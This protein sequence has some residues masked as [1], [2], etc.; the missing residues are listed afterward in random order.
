MS[1]PKTR[2]GLSLWG[3]AILLIAVLFSARPAQAH[4]ITVRDSSAEKSIVEQGGQLLADYGSS[5]LYEVD[6]VDPSVLQDDKA[7]IRDDYNHVFLNAARLDTMSAAT[8]ARRKPVGA[9]AGKRLHL[10]QFV[11]P[12]LPAWHEALKQTG[13]RIVSYIP[14]NTYLVYGDGPSLAQLQ[15]MGATMKSVQWDGEYQKDYKIHP[16][17]RPFD[18]KGNPRQLGTDEFA[19]Q[20]VED[21]DAN[22]ATLSLIDQLKLEPIHRQYNFLKCVNV[23]VRLHP[24]DLGRVAA[25]PDVISIQPYMEPR[26]EDERQD[27]IVAG[28]LTGNSPTGPGYLAWLASIGF[29]QSQFTASG[30]IVDITDA[31]IDDGT[32]NPGHFALYTL[33]DTNNASRVAYI[34]LEG[35]PNDGSTLQ[36]CDGHGNINAHIVCAYDPGPTNFPHTDS[37]G[38]FYDIGVCPFVEVGSSVIFDPDN[39]T[40]PSFA[41]LESQAYQDGARI[42]NNSWGDQDT[43][44]PYNS[45]SQAFDALVRDAQPSGSAFAANGN[46]EMVIVFSAG[47]GN[48]VPKSITAPGTGK[49]VFTVGGAENVRSMNQSNGGTDPDGNDGCGTPDSD[50]KSANNIADF[51]SQGPCSDGRHKPDIVAPCSHITGGAPQS[52]PPPSPDGTGL[53]LACFDSNGDGIC[54][55]ANGLFFPINQQFFT[56]SSGTSHSAPAVSGACA[57]LR[58]YFLNQSLTP[59]SPAMTKAYL[60]NSARY[61]TGSGANDDLWSDSQG[62]GELD[63]GTAFDGVARILRDQLITDIFTGSGQERSFSGVISDTSKPFRVTV[64]WS[65]APG[66]TASAAL[67]NDLDLTVTVGGTTY[68]GNVFSGA[69][70]V[71]GGSA[72]HLNN[73]ES[74]FLPAGTTGSF[75]VKITAANIVA[76]GVDGS[77]ELQQD[78]ALVIY[79]GMAVPVPDVIA[80]SATVVSESCLPTN[81]AIDPS[82]TVTVDF[83]L[84]N[85]GTADTT[86]VV[87]TLLPTGGVD[88]PSGPQAYGLLNTNGTPVAQPFSFIAAGP[89]GGSIT[90]TFQIQDG[91]TN[92]GTVTFI[93]PLG[94]TQSAFTEDFDSVT[95]PALP[96]GWATS[97]SGA[98]S[99]WVTSTNSADTPPN[100]AFSTDASDVGVNELDTPPI[101]VSSAHAQLTFRQNY[102]LEDDST[103]PSVGFDGGVL[104]IKIGSGAY[105]DIL[106]AG[107]SFVSGGYNSTISSRYGNPLAGRH[108][109]S[110]DSAGFVTTVVKLPAAAA[111]QM[112][113]LRWRCGTDTG[114]GETVVGWYIDTVSILEP[115]CCGEPAA[116]F[117]AVA[118]VYQGLIQSNSPSQETSG[119]ISVTTVKTNTYSATITLNGITYS[120]K[121]L[122]DNN[123]FST[124]TIPRK[125]TNSLT[126]LLELDLTNGT[127]Q[128]TGALTDGTFTSDVTANRATF[129]ART[130]PATQFAGYYTVLLP[131]NPG[132]TGPNFPQGNGFGSVK[133]DAGGTVRL[134]ATLGDGTKISQTAAVSKDGEWPL[135]VP[136]YSKKGSISGWVT[137]TN[138]VG[139]SDLGGTLSW[140]K[141]P[142]PGKFY[143]NGFASQIMFLGSA[144]TNTM[145]ALV[146]SNAPCNILVTAG[147]GN[148]GAFASNTITL[149]TN[150]KTAICVT[151]KLKLTITPK[152]GFFSG[153]FTNPATGKTLPFTGALLQ[154]QNVGAGL[155]SGT[156]QTGF[157]TVEPAP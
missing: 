66:S 31:G 16:L 58:Q 68:K 48:G 140:F 51:A 97:A 14:N 116:N 29:T 42:S 44:A 107:G 3:V 115:V 118:G 32:T 146:V 33:G 149:N 71:V 87:A 56:E 61:M 108:A 10:I 102:N 117:A 9:F 88:A 55:D 155:F 139:V 63:L 143:T 37:T 15:S 120:V 127:D 70:S 134:S 105:Q 18:E 24:Q 22:P 20:L 72:D 96:A 131:P 17:A 106:T 141:P 41:D 113:Q 157:V 109:W 114:N 125:G 126:M 84:K 73:V 148:L 122:F 138:I 130:N 36:S 154:K 103:T 104:E 110:G 90:N 91:G 136:L 34:R 54:G 43:G 67:N 65:D 28:N 121:G 85:V 128:I 23:F 39:F 6:K 99:P 45:D 12:V 47:N 74:V 27:Q 53:A 142:V 82:E 147:D 75:T 35:T 52:F 135:F 98:Q 50:A 129:N 145:P 79:N 83:T 119:L 86:N 81:G 21:P 93:L 8:K 156:N 80:D 40:N 62:M 5:R 2:P 124:L 150:D 89:C 77:S 95:A 78:F 19:I 49:N 57:L 69:N 153:S 11:G 26:K 132:D 94:A 60:M 137:F 133:V 123:G 46:Q 4:K 7:E 100:A 151:N 1:L 25:Q 13:A 92:L 38:Y 152:T 101:A 59:P 64:A 144:Y 111:G 30:F 112:I 76:D